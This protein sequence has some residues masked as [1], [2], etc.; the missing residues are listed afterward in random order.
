[1]IVEALQRSECI[2]L[3]SSNRLGRLGCLVDGTKPYVIPINYAFEPNYLYSFSM[4]GRK[5]EAM[6]LNPSVCVQVDHIGPGGWSSVIADGRYQELPDE[7]VFGVLRDRAWKLLSR[8]AD[9]WEPGSLKPSAQAQASAYNHIFYRV[10][11]DNLLGELA[12]SKSKAFDT[13][14]SHRGA[15]LP[16]PIVTKR[17]NKPS[18]R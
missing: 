6:R 5:I 16:R 11:V 14:L 2:E 17:L 1:M 15:A 9:W 4:P 7:S 12:C 10:E 18:H 3:L 8:H 13:T